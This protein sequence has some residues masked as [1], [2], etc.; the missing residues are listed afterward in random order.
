VASLS[1]RASIGVGA[2]A[3]L[4][5]C[6]GGGGGGSSSGGNPP[7]NTAPAFLVTTFAATEDQDL[8]STVTASDAN[9]DALTFASTSNP[10][11]GALT[12]AANGSFT[13]RPATNFSGPDS[14]GV[15]AND[16]HGGVTNATVTVNVAGVNDAPQAADDRVQLAYSAALNVP[17]LANDVDVDGE[18][19]TITLLE[20]PLVGIAAVTG[21]N[22]SI[23]GLPAAFRGLLRFRY[24]VRDAAATT[25]SAY[26]VV[27]VDT[28]PFRAVIPMLSGGRV[29]LGISNFIG[30]PRLL[31]GAEPA[32]TVIDSFLASGDGAVVAYH[33]FDAALTTNRDQLCAVSTVAGSVAGCY[34]IPDTLRLHQ[35]PPNNTRSVYTVSPNGRW[36][37]AVLTRA[38]STVTPSLYLIDTTNP[39]AATPV[40]A[41]PDA[42]HA[43]LPT[44]SS[45]SEHLYFIAS[46][47]LSTT[48]LGIYRVQPGSAAA[49]ERMSA[50]QVIASRV[51]G[52]TV[53]RDGT[54]L[55][56]QR[57]GFDPGVFMVATGAPAVEHR[58]SQPIDLS[59]ENLLSAVGYPLSA[60]PDLTA[61]AY[62]VWG[63]NDVKHLW[64][65]PVTAGG[66]TAQVIGWIDPGMIVTMWPLMRPDGRAMLVAFGSSFASLSVQEFSLDWAGGHVVGNGLTASYDAFGG[67]RIPLL[68]PV[69]NGTHY[70]GLTY[71]ATRHSSTP[72]VPVN[73]VGMQQIGSIDART[74]AFVLI[75]TDIGPSS[76]VYF[77]LVNL[78]APS[79]LLPLSATPIPAGT[80]PSILQAAIVSGG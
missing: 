40:T 56:F 42:P 54:R 31:T 38:D 79:A 39:T 53:S 24:Q 77:R 8:A 75:E 61:V 35:L 33:R 41:V 55:V 7:S 16:G 28:A 15:S 68:N 73:T 36:V 21:N 9:D 47:D 34:Q 67:D 10:A 43:I 48:G 63:N 4:T 74:G 59:F 37:A 72:P 58:L 52:L 18:A 14:F 30:E 1:I 44:F 22:V 49:P 32:G 50:S 60:D 78:A 5:A 27:F 23:T 17:V 11:H 12:F 65:A 26:A 13:Y 51:D 70:N 57:L 19:L 25:S 62:V 76:G 64:H 80:S 2:A 29:G 66:P 45:D 71:V 46:D 69:P 20:Q 6:G 3:I